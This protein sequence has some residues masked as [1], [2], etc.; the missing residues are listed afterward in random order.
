MLIHGAAGNVGGFAVQLA[1]AAGAHV[2]G[3]ASAANLDVVL[4]LGARD[5]IDAEGFED[6]VEPV[7]VVF[8]TVGGERL[9]HSRAVLRPGGRLVS[10]AEQPPDE[11][12]YFVVEPNRDQLRSI[13]RLV[14]R[15]EL[16]SPPVEVFPLNEATEAFA[17]SLEPRRRGKVVLA[18]AA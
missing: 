8:D 1:R 18:N 5:V 2:I 9:R 15:G 6:A 4:E 14:D 17:R 7:D 3:T 13:A 11:G 10:V 12:V 16:H